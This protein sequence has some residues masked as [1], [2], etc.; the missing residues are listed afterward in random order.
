MGT[1]KKATVILGDPR[2]R[3]PKPYIT[4]INSFERTF[5]LEDYKRQAAVQNREIVTVRA[6]PGSESKD[7]FCPSRLK[8]FREFKGLGLGG[9]V[10]VQGLGFKGS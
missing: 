3:D 10:R 1:P 5:K 7:K 2:S 4:P 8:H 9:S 6:L